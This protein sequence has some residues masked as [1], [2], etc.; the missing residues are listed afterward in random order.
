MNSKWT[1]MSYNQYAPMSQHKRLFCEQYDKN[2]NE[3]KRY[4][5]EESYFTEK[6]NEYE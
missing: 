6:E 4:D 1:E 5:N 3:I 2:I